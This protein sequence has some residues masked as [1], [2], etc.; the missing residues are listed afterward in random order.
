VVRYDEWNYIELMQRALLV[1]NMCNK[2]D[3]RQLEWVDKAREQFADTG[4][5]IL[6]VPDDPALKNRSDALDLSAVRSDTLDAL[7][8]VAAAILR[9]VN[10]FHME[11]GNPLEQSACPK[12]ANAAALPILHDRYQPAAH[13]E[14]LTSAPADTAHPV[15][16]GWPGEPA[17]ADTARTAVVP[18]ATAPAVLR[19]G[20]P[21]P[22]GVHPD[23]ASSA[24]VVTAA[25][26]AAPA[27]R[28]LDLEVD[29]PVK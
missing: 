28:Y 9:G 17:P 10:S 25:E 1:F 13:A 7:L 15:G 14:D 20:Q 23:A 24:V 3:P 5:Q 16:T 18:A 8:I 29:I 26:A 4:I 21:V 6:T 11:I 12:P 2:D 27:G 19:P 22:A